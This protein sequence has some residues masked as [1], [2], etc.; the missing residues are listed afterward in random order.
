MSILI[1]G[2]GLLSTWLVAVAVQPFLASVAVT[3]YVPAVKVVA[4]LAALVNPVPFQVITFGTPPVTLVPRR[5]TLGLLQ[6]I[7]PVLLA[8]TVGLAVSLI[9]STV[10]V[11]VQPF[12][13][14]V[15]VTVYAPDTEIVAGFV[16]LLKAGPFQTMTL[17]A[18]VPVSVVLV[19]VQFRLLLLPAV[20]T[21][22]TVSAF[23]CTVWLAVQLLPGSV[24][25]KV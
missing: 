14:S 6:L 2:L 10:A 9:T 23:T 4:G 13:G 17:P 24:T 1:V 20:T 3:V 16:A 5:F 12:A 18:L 7:G 22:E 25:I 19:R 15:A 11:F 21:A 8:V